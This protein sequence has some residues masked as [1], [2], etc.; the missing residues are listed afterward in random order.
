MTVHRKWCYMTSKIFHLVSEATM[1][2][3]HCPWLTACH[4]TKGRFY[5][6]GFRK[7]TS[8]KTLW[9][10]SSQSGLMFQVLRTVT[11]LSRRRCSASAYGRELPPNPR[12]TPNRKNFC[13]SL[14]FRRRE[15]KIDEVVN[16]GAF[17]P[18]RFRFRFWCQRKKERKKERALINLWRDGKSVPKL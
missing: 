8:E 2:H 16:F 15:E 10:A 6:N 18:F 14:F 1:C 4:K 11:P 5:K 17:T 3:N 12:P 9:T 7:L 13:R